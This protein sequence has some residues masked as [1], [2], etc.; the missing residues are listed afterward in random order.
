MLVKSYHEG[1]SE[2]G[3]RFVYDDARAD[4]NDGVTI[5]NGWVRQMALLNK[6]N[7]C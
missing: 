4:E 5:F 6:S 7:F 3:G 1:G 2:G